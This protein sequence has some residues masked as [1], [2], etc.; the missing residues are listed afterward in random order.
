MLF[1]GPVPHAEI[2]RGADRSVRATIT[3]IPLERDSEG[4]TLKLADASEVCDWGEAVGD[5]APTDP[6]VEAQS[7]AELHGITVKEYMELRRASFATGAG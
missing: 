4:A 1:L 3:M 2:G 6:L 5:R 7:Y